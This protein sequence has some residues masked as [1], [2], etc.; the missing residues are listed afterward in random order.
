MYRSTWVSQ[1][2][3]P[4]TDIVGKD[5]SGI[6]MQYCNGFERG[7]IY[8][9]Y[10]DDLHGRRRTKAIFIRYAATRCEAVFK[11][12]GCEC[13]SPVFTLNLSCITDYVPCQN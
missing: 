8:T 4:L 3:P 5:L 11:H 1:A 7:Q 6:V 9:I 12:C 13:K 2:R 10:W